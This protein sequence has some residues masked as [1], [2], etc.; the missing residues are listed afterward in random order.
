MPVSDPDGGLISAEDSPLTSCRKPYWW[1]LVALPPEEATM[2]STAAQVTMYDAAKTADLRDTIFRT[3]T[4]PLHTY[5]GSE[6]RGG[7]G[8]KALATIGCAAL[9]IM[10]RGNAMEAQIP[11]LGARSTKPRRGYQPQFSL[12]LQ[13]VRMDA[14]SQPNTCPCIAAAIKDAYGTVTLTQAWNFW[15]LITLVLLTR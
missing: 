14:P 13:L 7:D 5:R 6:T 15:R 8:R 10:T 3:T 12:N 11:G 2:I 1:P 9:I 4:E